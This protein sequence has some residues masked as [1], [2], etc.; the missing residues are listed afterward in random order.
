MAE[1]APGD[2]QLRRHHAEEELALMAEVVAQP[3]LQIWVQQACQLRCFKSPHSPSGSPWKTREPL[4]VDFTGK[5]LHAFGLNLKGQATRGTTGHHRMSEAFG[6][7]RSKLADVRH[8][9]QSH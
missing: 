7:A 6:G 5:P 8:S 3:V 9:V 4:F 1:P 2:V